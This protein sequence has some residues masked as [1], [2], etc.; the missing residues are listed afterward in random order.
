M[1]RKVTDRRSRVV[2]EKMNAK[3]NMN[4]NK[5]DSYMGFAAK[6]G[7][8]VTGYNTCMTPSVRKRIKLL[9]ISEDS[10]DGTMKKMIKLAKDFN[11]EY[12]V[13]GESQHLS[14]V[15]GNSQRY[16]FGITD[17]NFA[18]VIIKQIDE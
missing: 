17:A 4:S 1:E 10:S 7:N 8:L 2:S 16:I 18:D 11:I 9:I 15:T 12:R 6:S 13:F 14:K 5:I 3:R